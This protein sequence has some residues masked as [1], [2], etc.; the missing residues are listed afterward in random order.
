MDYWQRI[1]RDLGDG[2]VPGISVYPE[3]RKL[4]RDIFRLGAYH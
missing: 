3:E 2:K 4:I 1:Q